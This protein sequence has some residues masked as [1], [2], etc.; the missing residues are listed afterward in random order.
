MPDAAI[1]DQL[2]RAFAPIGSSIYG[3]G[4]DQPVAEDEV[5][6]VGNGALDRDHHLRRLRLTAGSTLRTNG[7]RLHVSDVIVIEPGA[8]LDS[9]EPGGVTSAV[10]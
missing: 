5:V 4:H 8:L 6:I 7:W 9:L 10:D 2:W 1:E 3:I